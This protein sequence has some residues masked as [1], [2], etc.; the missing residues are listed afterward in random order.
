MSVFK[1]RENASAPW[2]ELLMV[3]DVC[4]S[5]AVTKPQDIWYNA[6]SYGY[7]DNNQFNEI[8]V[9]NASTLTF[10]YDYLISSSTIEEPVRLSMWVYCGYKTDWNKIHAAPAPTTVPVDNTTEIITICKGLSTEVKG[11]QIEID[12]SQYSY[13]T[14]RFACSVPL[15]GAMHYGCAHIY[16]IALK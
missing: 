6:A 12:V 1:Y 7:T 4:T 10:S 11:N 8:N 15:D 16:D 5:L 14:I 3:G 13:V 2:K 9:S